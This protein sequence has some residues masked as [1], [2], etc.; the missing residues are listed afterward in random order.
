MRWTV[1]TVDGKVDV[2]GDNAFD[3]CIA[4]IKTKKFKSIAILMKATPVGEEVTDENTFYCD[5]LTVCK[6]AGMLKE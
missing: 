4:A 6:E 5:S 2:D 1:K 3:A